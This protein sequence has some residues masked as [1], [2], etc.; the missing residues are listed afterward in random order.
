[1][2]TES[3]NGAY[4]IA[5]TGTVTAFNFAPRVS[6]AW[7]NMPGR[8]RPER[9]SKIACTRTLRVSSS[10]FESNAEIFPTS[11]PGNASDVASTLAPT[12]TLPI[13]C[14]GTVK[15]TYA[16]RSDCNDAIV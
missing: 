13:S 2:K 15:L 14:C 9:L 16:G 8:S 11:G 12:A 6:C 1:M 5:D 10:T 4:A 7:T 3:P